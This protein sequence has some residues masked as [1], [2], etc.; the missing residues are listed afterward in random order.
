VLFLFL[1][2][3]AVSILSFPYVI[4]P[5]LIH[6]FYGDVL[7]QSLKISSYISFASFA[8]SSGAYKNSEWHRFWS[9]L[10]I[11]MSMGTDS[12]T[13]ELQQALDH[14]KWLRIE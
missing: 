5:I 10:S 12:C 2:A 13:P 14:P 3:W 11:G 7:D 8:S 9:Q 6:G 1:K 4:G